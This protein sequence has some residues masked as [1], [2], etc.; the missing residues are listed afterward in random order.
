MDELSMNGPRDSVVRELVREWLQNGDGDLEASRV[1]IAQAP[2]L[3]VQIG[4]HLQQAVEKY[5]KAYITFTGNQPPRTHDLMELRS[6]V[7]KHDRSLGAASAGLEVLVPYPVLE[8]YPQHGA[9]SAELDVASALE[10]ARRIRREVGRRTGNGGASED[11]PYVITTSRRTDPELVERAKQWAER[12]QRPLVER[13]GRSLAQI[14][15]DEGVEAVLTVTGERVGLVFPEGDVEYF[16]HPSMARTR[17]RNIKEGFGDPMVRAMA[18][19][20]G[21][22]VLDCTL[23]RATDATV[24]SWVVG[25]DGR[26]VG[27]EAQ[28]L[29]A[30]LTEEGLAEYEIEGAGVQE[31]MRRIDARQ[32][33]CRVLLPEMDSASFDVVYFDP[34]FGQMLEKS[35]SMKPLRRIGIHEPIPRETYEEARRVA[36]RRVVI[37][38]RR[39]EELPCVPEPDEIVSGG[40][41]RVEYLVLH[42]RDT[43]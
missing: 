10:L 26:V 33:D 30:A 11:I 3:V 18:L 23:G 32:G 19:E 7:Q 15:E 4:F 20:P 31:A 37:K 14:C 21:D 35:Q 41:S 25:E 5:L 22:S 13:G 38:Q 8:R 12:L 36:S 1:L 2:S 17:I 16:F 42:A 6:I 28:P 34:F 27:Y 39:S 29:V 40:G 9:T 43:D 24:A